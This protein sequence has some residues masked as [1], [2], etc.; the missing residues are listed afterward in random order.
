MY[1]AVVARFTVHF[2][3]PAYELYES[4]RFHK[5]IRQ[6]DESVDAYYAELCKLVKHC[7][8]PSAVIE[9]QLVRDKFVVGLRDVSFGQAVSEHKAYAQRGMD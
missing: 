3:H 7:N 1:N 8:Y 6:P 2:V 5:R 9:E 4:S